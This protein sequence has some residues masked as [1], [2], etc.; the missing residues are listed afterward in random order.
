MNL[1]CSQCSV[2]ALTIADG[3][4]L[5]AEHERERRNAEAE[6]AERD[7]QRTA[8]LWGSFSVGVKS[9]IVSIP[10]ARDYWAPYFSPEE[11]ERYAY[12]D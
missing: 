1:Q 5:C 9:Q 12:N 10:R 6:A 4:A 7:D 8:E 3:D 11:L 2:E